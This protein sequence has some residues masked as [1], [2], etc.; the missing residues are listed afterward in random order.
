MWVGANTGAFI[1]GDGNNGFFW[2]GTGQGL[3]GADYTI[4]IPQI[5][6]TLGGGGTLKLPITGSV[7]ALTVQPFTVHGI[8]DS[9]TG[10]P[11]NLQINVL[12]QQTDEIGVN[13][14]IP[15][16]DKNVTIPLPPLPISLGI[17]VDNKIGAILTP[18]IRISPITFNDFVVGGDS[19]SLSADVLGGLGPVTIPVF[20]L[21]PVPGFGNSTG[22]PSSGFFNSGAGGGSG[23]GN[24]GG[25]VSG[26]WNV[27]SQASG[28]QNLGSLVS[29]F[30]NK[31]DLLSG[32]NNTNMLGLSTSG[33]GNVG[34]H[35]S[36]LFFQGADRMSVFNAGLADVGVGNVG[37]GSVGDGNVGGG[38]HRRV[39]LR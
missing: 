37:F 27:A 26:W 25:G 6:L 10:I 28:Y 13:V 23:F 4:T 5:P 3:I 14:H 12:G 19:T 33:V 30:I 17:T 24:A 39:H 16:I 32:I 11:L 9:S 18:Q 22:V 20:Q 21:S 29:G 36:G 8:G 35:L 1:S 34:D 2:R 15:V 7:T 38:K 31:G